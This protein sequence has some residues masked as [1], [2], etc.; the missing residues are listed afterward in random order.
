[1][2]SHKQKQK[3]AHPVRPAIP[4]EAGA[5]VMRLLAENRAEEAWDLFFYTFI[6]DLRSQVVIT[7][8]EDDGES[9]LFSSDRGPF[10][11][12]GHF[13]ATQL[14]SCAVTSGH[15]KSKSIR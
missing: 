3:P 8:L 5:R 13:P 7:V 4:G 10:R 12:S 14:T 15:W 11:V 1:M 6:G 2:G 9:L